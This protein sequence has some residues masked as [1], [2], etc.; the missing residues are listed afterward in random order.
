MTL[1]FSDS[2][3]EGGF[4]DLDDGPPS[5]PGLNLGLI[6]DKP[7]IQCPP[8]LRQYETMAVLRPDMTEDERVGVIQ[9]YEEVK[10]KFS[11]F[12]RIFCT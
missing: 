12:E 4:E 9:K 6:E 10:I 5:L 8:G 1:D 2:L 3:F 7:D 11:C